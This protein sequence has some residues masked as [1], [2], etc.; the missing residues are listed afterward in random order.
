M[1]VTA[2]TSRF[3]WVLPPRIDLALSAG[4]L[5]AAELEVA[6]AVPDDK[7]VAAAAA[8]VING[9]LAWRRQA[10]T[11]V[12]VV[13]T[14]AFG[15][16]TA[17]GVP[18]NAQVVI[19]LSLLVAMYSVG[20]YQPLRR[21]AAGLLLAVTVPAAV[22]AAENT[23]T[24]DGVFAALV[25]AAP[26]LAGVLVHR[27][28]SQATVAQ[29][30]ALLAEAHAAQ[31]AQDAVDAERARIA[32]EL[33]D[34]V[35][36][37]LSAV[38]VQAAAAE[39]LL[40]VDPERARVPVQAIQSTGRHALQDMAGLLGLLRAGTTGE[41]LGPQPSL[42]DIDDLVAQARAAGQDVDLRVEGAP[43]DLPSGVGLSAYR[44]VQEAL[45]NA[46]K[47]AA[48]ATA[49]VVVSHERDALRLVV[50]DTGGSHAGPTGSGHGLVG[51][52][53]RVT[54]YGGTLDAGPCDR[55]WQVSACFPVD[56]Q[57]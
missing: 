36:H 38:V 18:Q 50:S 28:Q 35:T 26:W 8:V 21:A 46:R 30:R 22:L 47:H 27:Q 32:R 13:T 3:A 54:L 41:E 1:A 44:V 12:A 5:V 52:R 39:A 20:A 7:A 48:G 10:P 40:A 15:L 19:L 57:P 42:D 45:T 37:N 53:E 23:T 16:Q 34:V 6:L 31:Q 51:M 2:V 11:A 9:A 55:G 33:H 56:P 25:V 43:R 29:T 14:V 4:L 49:V 24:S 17:A